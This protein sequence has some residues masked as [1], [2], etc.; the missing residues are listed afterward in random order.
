LPKRGK[1]LT[2]ENDEEMPWKSKEDTENIYDEEQMD[3]MLEDDEIT[4]AEAAFMEG[5]EENP[6]KRK[7]KPHGDSDSVKT[8]E[9]DYYED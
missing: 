1:I 4:W 6:W 5:R 2:P 7:Y 9:L 3:K 8:S